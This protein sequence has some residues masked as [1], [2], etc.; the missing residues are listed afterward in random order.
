MKTDQAFIDLNAEF[1]DAIIRRW[2]GLVE[3]H[4][5]CRHG[6]FGDEAERTAAEEGFQ[7]SM[8]TLDEQLAALRKRADEA[9]HRFPLDQVIS[10][11]GLDPIEAS[12]LQLALVP[13]LELTFRTRIARYHNNILHDVIDVD[14]A[15]GLLFESRESRLQARSYFATDAPLFDNRLLTLAKAKEPKG[16]GLLAQE[17]RPPERLADFVLCRRSLDSSLVHFAELTEPELTLGDVALPEADTTNLRNLVQHFKRTEAPDANSGLA[18]PFPVGAGLT[19]QLV[20]PPGTG[21]TMIAKAIACELG[22][23]MIQVDCGTLNGVGQGFVTTIDALITEARVQGAVLVFDR[24]EPLFAKGNPKLPPVLHELERFGGLA[25]LTTSRPD[26]MDPGVERY[27]AWQMNMGLPEM[28]ERERI[29]T[30]HVPPS[31]QLAEDVD[32]EDL[33]TRFEVTGG[34]IR[35][36]WA[37]A[38]RRA[39]AAQGIGPGDESAALRIDQALLKG[40]AHAQIRA[41]MEDYSVRSKV[42]LSLDAL[43]LPEETHALI[44]EV[45]EACRNRVFVMSK[46][47]FGRRLVTGKGICVL[48]K[49]EPGTGKTFCSEILASELGMKLY[50]VSIPKIVSKY[51]GETE[52]RLAKLFEEAS[53]G[54]VAL[55]FDEADSLFA[56]RTSV[57]S[58]TDRYA[59][60]EVNF[61]LQKM[62]DFDGIVFLTTN[63]PDSLD[64]AFKR[65][66]RFHARFPLPDVEDRERLW[67]ALTPA[68]APISDDVDFGALAAAYEFSGGDVKNASLRAAF[69]AAGADGAI[70]LELLDKAAQVECRERGRLALRSAFDFV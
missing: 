59:N 26:E 68:D 70:T 31:A 53:R 17:L 39:E 32:L 25:I 37:V 3:H 65:R 22:R 47:G 8:R 12:I 46:W 30:L 15:L 2:E 7:T 10:T 54:G 58:S 62:E 41:N 14:M 44:N 66:I 43:V 64:E 51:I 63:M 38:V 11:Y 5:R 61:L 34:Q 16:S 29:W 56:K 6:S 52:E 21:K 18:A 19:I 1:I 4:I 49:G 24:C 69:Y 40:A 20:G 23:V 33:A 55:L 67:R 36:A 28:E 42:A 35:N 60:L 50:Q 13:Q 27:V 45:L 9:S 48:F 57:K